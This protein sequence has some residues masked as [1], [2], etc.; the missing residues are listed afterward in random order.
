MNLRTLTV[1]LIALPAFAAGRLPAQEN[2]PI[3][4]QVLYDN[5]VAKDAD[6]GLKADWGFGC[7]VRGAEKT[8]LV[9][10]GTKGDIFLNNCDKLGVDLKKVDAVV[11][12]HNHDDHIGGLPSM[13]DRN[14]KVTVYLPP[15][16]GPADVKKVEDRGAKVVVVKQRIEICKNV[17]VTTPLPE[18]VVEQAL[19]IDM[20]KGL[21]LIT[22]CSHP[23]VAQ[24]ARKAKEELKRDVYL[25]C[26][27]THLSQRS[28]ADI[29][30][31]IA[32][33]KE[34]GVQKV[35]PSHCTGDKAA[36]FQKAFG[37]T[38]VPMGA[39]KVVRP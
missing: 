24:M 30:S 23:G 10:T 22:G 6:K 32:E 29:Q 34:L 7:I 27:G 38:F 5:Y 8:I 25:V 3:E 19:A 1:A 13:L 37:E 21:V 14:P 17:Y 11:I 18:N 33:L 20:P 9:D 12:S 16:C 2:K 4:I 28:D 15:S 39:G 36:M 26:G 31:T 35:G